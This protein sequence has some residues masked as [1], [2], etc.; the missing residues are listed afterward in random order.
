MADKIFPKGVMAFNKHEKAPDFV[1]GTIIITPNDL[2]AWLKGEGADNLMDS[3][4][5][6][7]LKLQLTK[8]KDGKLSIAVDNWKP[9][10]QTSTYQSNSKPQVT[11]DDNVIGAD[12]LPF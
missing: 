12:N 1:I 8:S 11:A 9:T 3:K 2:V 10:A 7:Q 5:G 4:Y 6:K